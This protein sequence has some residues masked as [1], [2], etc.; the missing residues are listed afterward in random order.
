MTNSQNSMHGG[1]PWRMWWFITLSGLGLLFILMIIS[2]QELVEA[3]LEQRIME[4]LTAENIDWITIELDGR[5]R[6]VLLKGMAP[7]TESRELVIEM[8]EDA[9]GVRI[10]D[11]QIEI[12][13]SLSSSELSIQQQDGAVLLGGRLVSQE[14]IDTVV[15]AANQ[16]YGN[17]NVVSELIVSGEVK[18][19]KWLAASA[20]LLPTLVRMKSAHLKVSD[21]E[22]LLSAEVDSHGERLTLVYEARKL[23]GNNLEA[24]VTV[25]ESSKTASARAND[26]K[27]QTGA[28]PADPRL[29]ACQSKLDARMKEKKIL[30]AFNTAEIQAASYTLLDQIID[31]L[32]QCNEVVMKNKLTI[33]G[34][35]DSL[36]DD[37]YNLALSQRRADAVKAYI[38][39]AVTDVG[40]IGSV[41]YGENQPVESNDT[42]DGRT[43]NRRIEFKLERK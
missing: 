24:N 5:G 16:T 20:G 39:N 27:Q 34:H 2:R 12:K 17:E 31:V 18:T 6:D 42:D 28:A 21:S 36:G 29:E 23:L 19:A 32:N 11:N 40:L 13:P 26:A 41:G 10:I 22:S 9:Y 8:V 33:A 15:N 37:A 30:F 7:S 43:Q 38:V 1:L 4:Q 35:T 25:I 14:S 3:D